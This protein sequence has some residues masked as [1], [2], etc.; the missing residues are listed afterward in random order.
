MGHFLEIDQ[1]QLSHYLTYDFNILLTRQRI[2]R[3]SSQFQRL[4][5]STSN[6]QQEEQD[7]EHASKILH[8]TQENDVGGEEGVVYEIPC[9][10]WDNA[11]VGEAG[12]T[13]KKH[14]LGLWAQPQEIP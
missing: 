14:E 2:S 8:E 6:S 4:V 1:Q 12:W 7:P 9:Q 3:P 13:F 10:D 11:C 5:P